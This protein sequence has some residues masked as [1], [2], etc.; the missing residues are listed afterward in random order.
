MAVRPYCMTV[1]IVPNLLKWGNFDLILLLF[2]FTNFKIRYCPI[3]YTTAITINVAK[4][5]L[6]DILVISEILLNDISIINEEIATETM[7]K[8][9]LLVIFLTRAM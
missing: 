2:C 8:N 3:T 4:P 1:I 9:I 7:I 6:V 5:R